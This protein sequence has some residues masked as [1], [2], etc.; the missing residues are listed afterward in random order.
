M[1]SFFCKKKPE[2]MSEDK[3]LDLTKY[4]SIAMMVVMVGVSGYYWITDPSKNLPK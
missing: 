3:L 2:I 4:A 1:R